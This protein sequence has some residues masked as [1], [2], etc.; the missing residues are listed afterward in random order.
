MRIV[1]D[2]IVYRGHVYDQWGALVEP[3]RFNSNVFNHY[4]QQTNFGTPISVKY[5]DKKE[6]C[7]EAPVNKMIHVGT[8]SSHIGHFLLESLQKFID[9][10]YFPNNIPIVVEFGSSVLPDGIKHMPKE[11]TLWVIQSFIKNKLISVKHKQGYYGDIVYVPDKYMQISSYCEKPYMFSDII[12]TIVE[13]ARKISNIEP[14]DK[15]YLSRYETK[16]VPEGF[17]ANDPTSRIYDQIALI[18]YAKELEGDHGSNTHLSIFA[19]AS[20][21]YTWTQNRPNLEASRNQAMMDLIK[22]F[23]T[24]QG[25]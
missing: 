19:P 4:W 6:K 23:N 15:V 2:Y 16:E 20:C 12:K 11:D 14:H 17:K 22:S 8:V 25:E 7:A 3:S 1:K 24:F 21:K 5:K 10:Y 13:E 18:S 9:V